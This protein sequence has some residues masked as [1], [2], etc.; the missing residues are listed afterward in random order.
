MTVFR[1]DAE[2]GGHAVETA[3]AFDAFIVEGVVD[4]GGQ[5]GA[6]GGFGDGKLA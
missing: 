5:V 1:E 2:F 3:H 6:D 4:V